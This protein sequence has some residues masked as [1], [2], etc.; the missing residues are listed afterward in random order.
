M[1]NL[2]KFLF[3][4]L[5]MMVEAPGGGGAPAAA[6]PAAAAPAAP[7]GSAAAAAAPAASAAP[8]AAAAPAATDWTSSFNDD[9]KGYAT[10]KGWKDPSQLLDSYRNLEKLQGVP[11]DQLLKLPKS[12][13]EAAEWT[14]IFKRLGRPDTADGYK[15]EIPQGQDPA[16]S[17]QASE[18]FHEL[19]LSEKQ[20]Q[21]LT[22]KW[23]EYQA[24][25]GKGA[26]EAFGAKVQEQK[27]ILKKDWGAAH[28]QNV[29]IAARAARE[30]GVGAKALDALD[31]SIG[32]DA[33]MKLFH[34]IGA[35]MG[36]A[37]FH[38]GN[39]GNGNN[40]PMTPV[41]AQSK[42]KT[43]KSDPSFTKKYLEGD[44]G[45]RVEMQRLH[46]FAYPEA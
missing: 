4:G 39:G 46:E 7:A 27:G 9:M 20:G 14:P 15:L 21:N 33:T 45:A 2:F 38:S 16:F 18:W 3:S 41:Q 19:G 5:V 44:H 32:H 37:N 24:N 43:L 8:A 30:F 31:A 29:Q 17:K 35:K 13:A 28:D 36:E 42:I 23:N 26:T 34:Q 22:K 10:N 12:D 1:K 40:G 25:Q 6:A 11:Q